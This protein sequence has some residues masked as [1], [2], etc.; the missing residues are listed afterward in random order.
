MNRPQQ[1]QDQE[2]AICL[3]MSICGVCHNLDRSACHMGL[4]TA[5]S[6][7]LG[8]AARQGCLSCSMISRGIYKFCNSLPSELG[9]VYNY[10]NIRRVEITLQE[11]STVSL[12]LYFSLH[13]GGFSTLLVDLFSTAGMLVSFEIV[14]RCLIIRRFLRLASNPKDGRYSYDTGCIQ[15]G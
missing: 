14:F 2:S 5:T 15:S 13:D 9:T 8:S 12:N 10:L 11:H 1:D 6:E 4:A 7:E 3:S